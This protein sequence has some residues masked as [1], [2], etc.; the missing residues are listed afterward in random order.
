MFVRDIIRATAAVGNISVPELLSKAART[1]DVAHLRQV[2]ILVSSRLTTRSLPGLGRD[3]G[4][5]DHTTVLHAV[6][7]ATARLDEAVERDVE[8]LAGIVAALGLERLPDQSAL[9]WSLVQRQRVL[10]E[11]AAGIEAN[12]AAVRA[13]LN[14]VDAMISGI[15]Q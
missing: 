11:L 5:R 9:Q 7:R 8:N 4:K 14:Q 13:E 6:R 1:H 3:W 12:L 15:V 2:G 10:H